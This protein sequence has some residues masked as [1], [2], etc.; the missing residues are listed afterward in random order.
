MSN[1]LMLGVARR[2]ITPEIGTL[3]MG[4]NPHTVSEKINDN[5]NATAFVFSYGDTKAAMVSLD[6]CVISESIADMLRSKL[7]EMYNIPVENIMLSAIHTHSGPITID[8]VGW[9]SSDS[10][11]CD[12]ILYPAIYEVVKE[13]NDN[14]IPVEMG[15]AFGDSFVGCNRR[16]LND[17]NQIVLGQSP[18]S[19]FNPKMTVISF[20]DEN[21]KPIANMVHYGCHATAAGNNLE[22]SR[23]WPGVMVDRLEAESGAITA[24][25][26]GPEGDV[27]PRL[28]NGKTTGIRD[29][30]YAME[31]GAVA[32]YDAVNIYKKITSYSN[33]SLSC[34]Q[35]N[36]QLKLAPRLSYE[37]AKEQYEL[38]KNDT[39]N[40]RAQLKA[41]YERII[42][43]YEDGYEDK[44]YMELPTNAIKLGDIAFLGLKYELFSEIGMR[45]NKMS[46][47]G[48]VLSLSCT[49]GTRGYFPTQDQ[50]C[51]GGYEI[52]MFKTAN[53]QPYEENADYNMITE[54]LKLLDMLD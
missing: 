22:I 13:A 35:T 5:L 49:N 50:L 41:Y 20:R 45:I 27:G 39:V 46:S 38:Y 19:P 10:K 24:F 6:L 36:L 32:A 51:R 43:S 54:C 3:L 15:Y 40:L 11:Y 30:K 18:W 33:V 17:K 14:L 25:F 52:S 29:I 42:K 28:S 4:Y 26:N 37:Y 9:G 34:A 48:H 2:D 8:Q 47:I 7:C 16:E 21:K 12:D 53:L 1:K 31:I 23:D 44:E